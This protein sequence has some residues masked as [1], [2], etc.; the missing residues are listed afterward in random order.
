MKKIF[1]LFCFFILIPNFPHAMEEGM[2]NPD[3]RKGNK[4]KIEDIEVREIKKTKNSTEITLSNIEVRDICL[5]LLRQ[6]I[7]GHIV[8]IGKEQFFG[9]EEK[10]RITGLALNLQMKDDKIAFQKEGFFDESIYPQIK[11]L[12]LKTHTFPKNLNIFDNLKKIFVD[13]LILSSFTN[14]SSLPKSC[15]ELRV[16]FQIEKS[17]NTNAKHKNDFLQWVNEQDIKSLKLIDFCVISENNGLILGISSLYMENLTISNR[18]LNPIWPISNILLNNLQ[19]LTLNGYSFQIFPHVFSLN[20]LKKLTILNHSNLNDIHLSHLPPALQELKINYTPLKVFIMPISGFVNLKHIDLS[21]NSLLTSAS[22]SLLFSVIPNVEELVLQHI[23]TEFLYTLFNGLIVTT[24]KKSSLPKL[25][26][27][28]LWGVSQIEQIKNEL[29]RCPI[30]FLSNNQEGFKTFRELSTEE[31]K[32]YILYACIGDQ[33]LDLRQ[34]VRDVL[35]Q[36]IPNY[37]T[38]EINLDVTITDTQAGQLLTFS[39]LFLK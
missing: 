5:Q 30:L 36:F 20:R 6:N 1:N 15:K 16:H 10:S 19:D 24:E 33:S 37:S 18:L 9:K 32:V 2:E 4:R 12:Y 17:T 39:E 11:M 28:D 27:L 31:R 25:R 13:G 8:P 23:E 34:E 22:L 29:C 38:L 26:K 7:L 35:T 21:Y 3:E 14:E